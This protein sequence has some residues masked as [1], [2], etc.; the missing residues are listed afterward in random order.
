M[1]FL[2]KF[3]ICLPEKSRNNKLYRKLSISRINKILEDS[4]WA[5]NPPEYN[6]DLQNKILIPDTFFFVLQGC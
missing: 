6:Y 1:K 3:L 5:T 2:T 4:H